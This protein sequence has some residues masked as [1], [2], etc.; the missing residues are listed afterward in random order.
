MFGSK[1]KAFDNYELRQ[2]LNNVKCSNDL[3]RVKKYVLTYF[4]HCLIPKG[5]LMWCDGNFHHYNIKDVHHIL[6]EEVTFSEVPV[7]NPNADSSNSINI[8]NKKKSKKSESKNKGKSK[9][10]D[11]IKVSYITFNVAKWFLYG[12]KVFYKIG[13]DPSKSRVYTGSN[14]QQYIN[15]FPGYLYRNSPPYD[16]YSEEIKSRVNTIIWHMEHVLCSDKKD[17][18]N[19]L[20]GWFANLI[21]GTKMNKAIFFH[22]GQGTGKSIFTNFIQKNVLGKKITYKT[23]NEKVITGNFNKELEGKVLLVLEEMSGSKTGDWIAFANR[24]KDFIDGEELIIEEKC[25]TPYPVDNIISLVINSNNS[26]AVRLDRDDRRYFIPDISD[27]YVGNVTYFNELKE[28]MD[29]PGVG[30]AFYV[31]MKSY[32]TFPTNPF[33]EVI[34]PMTGMKQ[35]MVGE[36][37]HTVHQF[38]KDKYLRYSFG[39]DVT[40][41]DLYKQFKEWH[42]SEIGNKKPPIIQ[43]FTRKLN[44]IGLTA[45]QKRKNGKRNMWYEMDFTELYANCDKKHLMDKHENFNDPNDQNASIEIKNIEKVSKK[46]PPKVPPKPDSLRVKA[47]SN[48]TEQ[49]PLCDTSIVTQSKVIA[50]D[51]KAVEAKGKSDKKNNEMLLI[52]EYSSDDDE[53][54]NDYDGLF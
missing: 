34:M 33:N 30:E 6:S 11:D 45:R 25:K 1:D 51:N 47:V 24:L 19:Y 7:P 20:L 16:T 44:D 49:S 29:Y 36:A 12:H 4:A 17:Q 21:N 38:I 15:K 5:V 41:M 52:K 3:K 48:K 46:I 37:I 26:K 23:A 42:Y 32:A 10:S 8:N 18:F 31:F 40:S 35:A 2:L 14:G 50:H 53:W 13:V 9:D 27:V 43:E 28:A 54:I 39:I 22:S